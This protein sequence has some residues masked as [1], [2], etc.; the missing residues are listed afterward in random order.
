MVRLLVMARLLDIAEFGYFSIGILVSSTFSMLGCLGLQT[1]LQRDSPGQFLREQ[2]KQVNVLT[3]QSCMVAFALCLVGLVLVAVTAVLLDIEGTFIA[4]GLVHGLSQQL[5][6]IATVESRSRGDAIRYAKQNLLRSAVLFCASFV[7]AFQ[8]GSAA[9]LLIVEATITIILSL[10]F[11]K[12]GFR[13]QTAVSEL[14]HSAYF[15]LPRIKWA[16]AFMLLGS[17]MYGILLTN[18]DR[19]IA[20]SV[21]DISQFAQYSFAWIIL[22][23]AQSA[24]SVISASVFPYVAVRYASKGTRAAFMACAA[25]AGGVGLLLSVLSVPAYFLLSFGIDKWYP[26]YVGVIPLLPIFLCIA[27]L[28]VSDF[29]RT[30]MLVCG[31]ERML[32]FFNSLSLLLVIL[33]VVVAYA[34]GLLV[35]IDGMKVAYLALLINLTFVGTTAAV[36]FLNRGTVH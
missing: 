30:F 33:A 27:I 9:A 32:V 20:S 7:I 16:V 22:I 19:W 18:G 15:K 26:H 25:I 21:L 13:D 28:Q 6:L 12:V 17:S 34:A 3:I 31:L 2:D 5:F 24:Q 11:L 29:W 10:R 36:S 8:A 23:I 14:I 35:Q 4:L 1:M